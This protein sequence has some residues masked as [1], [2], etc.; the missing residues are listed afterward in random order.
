MDYISGT[1]FRVIMNDKYSSKPIFISF[2]AKRVVHKIAEKNDNREWSRTLFK[3]LDNTII[4]NYICV[5]TIPHYKQAV[6]V[7]AKHFE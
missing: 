3:C 5:F 2:I 6:F 1:V 4:N 7:K